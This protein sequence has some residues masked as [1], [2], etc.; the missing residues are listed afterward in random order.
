MKRYGIIAAVV[1]LAGCQILPSTTTVTEVSDNIQPP[2]I[3][4]ATKCVFL[5]APQEPEMCEMDYWQ[6]YWIQ[7]DKVS[8]PERQTLIDSMDDTP[9]QLLKKIILSQPVN[10]PYKARLRAQHWIEQLYPWLAAGAQSWLETVVSKPSGHMLELESAVTILSNM[11]NQQDKTLTQQ[12]RQIQ[13]LKAQLEAL[14]K[15]ES[16]LMNQ[17]ETEQ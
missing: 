4:A 1:G 13:K 2:A 9:D 6:D 10:T 3:V 15:I 11:N 12:E 14:M 17:E 5:I 7:V 16:N 8:W